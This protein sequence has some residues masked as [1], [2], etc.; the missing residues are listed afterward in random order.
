MK[1]LLPKITMHDLQTAGVIFVG[2]FVGALMKGGPV[3]SSL[4]YSALGA[5]VVALVHAYLGKDA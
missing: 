2:A 5:G 1:R 4:I 3:T